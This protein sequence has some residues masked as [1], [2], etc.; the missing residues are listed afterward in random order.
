[1]PTAS[2][3]RSTGRSRSTASSTP[4]SRTSSRPCPSTTRASTCSPSTGPGGRRPRAWTWTRSSRSSRAI[5]RRSG[6]AR[7]PADADREPVALRSRDGPAADHRGG[8]LGVASR[9]PAVVPALRLAAIDAP[10]A[11]RGAPG[12]PFYLALDHRLPR[13]HG[14]PDRG[15]IRLHLPEPDPVPVGAAAVHW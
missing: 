11:P 12:A 13:L 10:G 9:W 2:P 15:D 14:D 4:T 7:T 5:F 6:T 1:R 8:H 3:P